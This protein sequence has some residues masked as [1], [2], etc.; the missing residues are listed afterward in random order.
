VFSKK[1]KKYGNFSRGSKKSAFTLVEALVFLFIFSVI[2]VTFYRVFSMSAAFSI[3]AKKRMAAT[4]LANEKMEI[5]R[6]LDYSVLGTVSGIPP[7]NLLGTETVNADGGQY[8]IFTEVDYIDDA[9][10]GKFPADAIPNDY[11]LVRIKVAWVNDINTTKAVT[12]FSSFPP[13]GLETDIPNSGVL[14]VNILDNTGKG[15]PQADILLTNPATGTNTTVQTDSTGNYTFIG[16]TASSKYNVQV[17]KNGYYSVQTYPPYP[18]S[19]FNPSDLDASVMNDTVTTKSLITDQLCQVNLKTQDPFGT[20][21]P[22]VGF[23]LAGGHK[24]GTNASTGAA[25]YDY[26]QS[27]TS[28]SSGTSTQSNMSFGV[29]TVTPTAV[30]GKTF[31]GISPALNKNNQFSLNPGANLNVNLLYADNSLNS[32]LITV[33]NNA[34]STPI[35]GASVNLTNVSGYNATV[36]TDNYGDAYFPTS[37]PALTAG[38][39]TISVTASGFKNKSDTVTVSAYTVKQ[40]KLST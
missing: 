10:D 2:A 39:Y 15:I 12:V 8:Y 11:K 25:M 3:D 38:Q 16:A 35:T 33:L 9:F 26:N 40:I 32:T 14:S 21:I 36:T 1:I 4:E 29:Y 28:N 22:S 19:A 30:T 13:P 31:I 6:N 34:D 24:K 20:A 27:L 18:T 5:A 17:S 7:G 23:T 37:M